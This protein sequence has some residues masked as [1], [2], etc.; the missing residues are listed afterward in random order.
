MTMLLDD[1]DFKNKK[2]IFHKVGKLFFGVALV[3]LF[4]GFI[5]FTFYSNIVF[6]VNDINDTIM[7]GW[8]II[9]I[10][11]I[12]F[13][14]GAFYKLNHQS[15][16]IPTLENLA[17]FHFL[18]SIIF[19]GSGL[20]WYF[21]SYSDLADIARRGNFNTAIEYIEDGRNFPLLIS[22]FLLTQCFFISITYISAPST[23]KKMR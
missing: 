8:A 12:F 10:A 16:R 11:I 15:L 18:Y 19:V 1:L 2:P 6:Y 3:F 21:Y 7:I 5:L 20:T 22:L 4:I 13:L 9:L 17:L 14:L 23:V